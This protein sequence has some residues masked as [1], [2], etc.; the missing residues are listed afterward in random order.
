M[1]HKE[2]QEMFIIGRAEIQKVCSSAGHKWH[3]MMSIKVHTSLDVRYLTYHQC[4]QSALSI[5][6]YS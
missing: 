3:V 4:Y 6:L 5:G 2:F 1:T